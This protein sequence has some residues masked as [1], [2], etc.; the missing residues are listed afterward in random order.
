MSQENVD[1]VGN[2][3][4]CIRRGDDAGALA[5][6]APGVVYGV[7]QEG[8]AHGPDAVRAMWGRWESDWAEGGKTVA[9]EFIDAGDQVVVTVHESGRGRGS[10]IEVDARVF[11]VFTLRDSKIVHKEEFTERSEALK[12]AGLSE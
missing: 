2:F 12:A 10:G 8:P 4:E 1:I 9:E 5:C 3:Y 11:N 7:L 6:L